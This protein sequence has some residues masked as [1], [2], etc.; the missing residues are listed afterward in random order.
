MNDLYS[1]ENLAASYNGRPVLALESLKVGCGEVVGVTGPNG[2]GK[3]TLLRILAFLN[4]PTTGRVLFDGKRIYPGGKQEAEAARKKAGLLLQEPYLLRRSVYNNVA[5]GLKIR[6][7][8]EGIAEAVH[9]A[10]DS[11]GLDPKKFSRRLWFELSGGEKSRVALAARLVLKPC[12]LLLDEPTASL[13]I[14]SA[15]AVKSAVASARSSF[16]ASIIIAGHD[17]EWMKGLCDRFVEL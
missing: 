7:E 13:D 1:I 6:G 16:N 14:E 12:A 8:K 15:K 5:Y 2:S 17:H 11:V 10:L 3:S 4:A 9:M